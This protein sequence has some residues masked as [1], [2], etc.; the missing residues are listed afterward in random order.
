M[1]RSDSVS[2]RLAA[3]ARLLRPQ[4]VALVGASD[5]PTSMGRFLLSNLKLL[6]FSGAIH[7]VSRSR[8]MLDG[9]RCVPA[10][11]DLPDGIDVAVL[12]IPAAG[13][14][15]AVR[16]CGRRNIRS[17]V[18]FSSGFAE[19]GEA[20]E[21]AQAELA[22]ICEEHGVFLVGPNCMGLTSYVTA[23]PL[24]FEP[25]EVVPGKSQRGLAVIAQSGAMANN[26]RD[27]AF[28]RGLPVSYSISTGNEASLTVE[29]FFEA[30][31]DD[32]LVG[33]FAIYVEQIRQPARFL[34]LARRARL[35]GK[36]V[37]LLMPGRSS[38]AREAVQ[39]HTGALAGDH[40]LATT[41]LKRE[42][43]V[44]VDTADELFDCAAILLHYPRPS[45]TGPAL[46][47]NS[48]ALKNLALDLSEEVGLSFPYLQP[49]TTETL[50][51]LLPGFATIDN[52]LDYTVGGSSP[53]VV[54]AMTR[55]LLADAH[56]G[57]VM[58][59]VMGGA[60]PMQMDKARVM[61]PALKSS[62]KPGILVFMGD[63]QP[64]S[65]EFII[66]QRESGVPFFRSPDR[67]VRALARV[68]AFGRAL[69]A[70][71]RRAEPCTV[72][73][74]QGTGTLPE[75]VGKAWLAAL[76]L[77]VPQGG[78]AKSADEACAIAARIGYPVVLKAQAARLAHKSEAGGVIIN[79]A[80][81]PAL[82]AAWTRLYA[83]VA[84]Y[85]ATLVLDGALVE[86]MAARGLELVVGGRRD[87]EWG[88]VVLVGLGGIWI[89]VLKD[90]RLLP[91]DLTQTDIIAALNQLRAAALL[92]GVR[93]ETAV[94]IAAVARTVQL[95]GA[96]MRADPAISEIDINPL[97]ARP[98]GVTALDAL[99]VRAAKD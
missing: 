58:I 96:A 97:I 98:D 87:P 21:A 13:V 83:N 7:L 93:G 95:V 82:R 54:D 85:D 49:E 25:L 12:A 1:Q 80:D 67:A 60:A 23:T 17:V 73:P 53:K 56:V 99:V 38:R 35:A 11:D 62:A 8:E 31:L 43:V 57:A 45:A 15:D 6:G 33:L 10:I 4:A 28:G 46:M 92:H 19:A 75:Y 65:P 94:D 79:L 78:L 89:E 14:L 26:F 84:A 22:R 61:F 71:E 69:D 47:T 52:P 20:G 37:V 91:A 16:A 40:A 77:S 24:T 88:P 30:L 74:L 66:A 18:V 5:E 3:V 2:M 70:A 86:T 34:H 59:A 44:A 81:E 51:A 41:L 48:G 36:P 32:P 42:A 39:S 27:A 9:I 76:G 55:A 63:G 29:D 68:Q 64:L 72:T 90:V 50:R